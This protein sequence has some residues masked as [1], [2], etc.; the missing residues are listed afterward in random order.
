MSSYFMFYWNPT[1]TLIQGR[2]VWSK[3]EKK[4]LPANEKERFWAFIEKVDDEMEEIEKNLEAYSYETATAGTRTIKA[5]RIAGKGKYLLAKHD[6]HR[7]VLGYVLE[8]PSEIGEVQTAFDITHEASFSLAVKNPKK[9]SPFSAG[10]T[11]SQKATFP[12][13]IQQR[14]GSYQWLPGLPFESSRIFA[15]SW[16]LLAE[17]AMLDVTGCEMV[18]IGYSTDDLEEA[19]GELARELEDEAEPEK[20]ATEVM[21]EIQLDEEQHPV[22]PLIDGQWPSAEE[23]PEKKQE[24][25]DS[26]LTSN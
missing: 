25:I 18:W 7:T 26:Y 1:T 12:D 9:K 14:F 2:H 11:Q 24:N 22:Q 19:L 21:K 8:S 6:Q 13:E 17:P 15:F 23:A 16:S 5:D 3:L 10:L 4:K 20:T